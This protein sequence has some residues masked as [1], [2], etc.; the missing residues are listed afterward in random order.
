MQQEPERLKRERLM[1][2]FLEG[3]TEG[4][5]P[6]PE[7]AWP[8]LKAALLDYVST[9]SPELAP[10]VEALLD[11]PWAVRAAVAGE[12]EEAR[13]F[14]ALELE[15]GPDLC[16]CIDLVVCGLCIVGGEVIHDPD[17]RL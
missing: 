5:L 6:V 9:M 14:V 3:R 1:R 10:R 11:T 16:P 8:Q 17:L 15:G 12:G 13:V 2:D 7:E 4:M